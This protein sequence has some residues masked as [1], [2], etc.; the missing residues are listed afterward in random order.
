MLK[1]VALTKI[2]SFYALQQIY[3]VRSVIS[4]TLIDILVNK[5]LSDLMI[6]IIFKI[7]H[8]LNCF[9]KSAYL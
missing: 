9:L 6:I 1:W 5:A 4:F 3:R 8:E 7:C 2:Y